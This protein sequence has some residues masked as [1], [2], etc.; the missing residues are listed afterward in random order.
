M[1]SPARR[2][3]CFAVRVVNQWCRR[4]D[5]VV[6]SPAA[7]GR[8]HSDSTLALRP[9]LASAR[10]DRAGCSLK[11]SNF[12]ISVAGVMHLRLIYRDHEMLT[13][14]PPAKPF[15]ARLALFRHRRAGDTIRTPPAARPPGAGRATGAA[16]AAGAGAASRAFLRSGPDLGAGDATGWVMVHPAKV[17]LQ[18]LLRN[19]CISS[20]GRR[21]GPPTGQALSVHTE[22]RVGQEM[23]QW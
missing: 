10:A 6:V 4:R 13:R 19:T 5:A 15:R 12:M 1:V 23:S 21:A 18:S 9:A 7:R 2:C 16:E 14:R 17:T 20:W 8:H 22:S 3:R 11:R